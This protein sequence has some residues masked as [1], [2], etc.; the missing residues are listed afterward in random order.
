MQGLWTEKRRD[1]AGLP[2]LLFGVKFLRRFRTAL[3][4]KLAANAKRINLPSLIYSRLNRQCELSGRCILKRHMR[5]WCVGGAEGL[6]PEIAGEIFGQFMSY[7][8][9]ARA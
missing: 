5:Q 9:E 3:A 4:H 1:D 6:E 2:Q 7:W 8:L